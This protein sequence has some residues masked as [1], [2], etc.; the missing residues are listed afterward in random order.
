MSSFFKHILLIASLM[1][2]ISVC[3]SQTLSDTVGSV[4]YPDSYGDVKIRARIDTTLM[5]IGDQQTLHIQ[6]SNALKGEITIPK[7]EELTLGALEALEISSD[8]TG[9]DIEIRV[10]VTSFEAGHHSIPAIAISV[11]L[12]GQVVEISPSDSLFV[13]VVYT[14]DADTVKCETR[15]DVSAIRE[16]YT[17][18]E[19]ARWGVYAL[20]AAVVIAIIVWVVKR[21]REHKPIVVLPKSKP[22]SADRRAISELEALRRKELWQKGR[23]KRYYTELTDIVRRFLQNMY[24][25]TAREMTTRQILRAFHG[26]RDW[27]EES[28]NKL[29]QLLQQADMVKFA[30]SQP[31]AYEHDKAMQLAVDFVKNVAETHW[32]NNPDESAEKTE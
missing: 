30:K 20:L 17:F 15:G 31:E 12:D 13:E 18:W 3:Q 26:I 28:E 24:G 27:S 22:V 8:T 16:P 10:T 4:R 25:I 6:I 7:E 14:S 19:I 1:L 21:R 9:D 23:I 32:V 2:Y 11:A 29:K 5:L